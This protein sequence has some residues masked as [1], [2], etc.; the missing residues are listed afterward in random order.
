MG[1]FVTHI[2]VL[3]QGGKVVTMQNLDPNGVDLA[4]ISFK[5]PSS[6]TSLTAYEFCNLHGLWQGP[7]IVVP[8][9]AQTPVDVEGFSLLY[10]WILFGVSGALFLCLLCNIYYV[11]RVRKISG[12]NPGDHAT[13]QEVD[14]EVAEV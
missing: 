5:V 1:H 2:Y 3:D 7:T 12:N 13:P 11:G 6:A 8:S 4:S 9:E 14:P 10:L